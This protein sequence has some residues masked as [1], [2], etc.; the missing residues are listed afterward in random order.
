[1]L[2]PKYAE[3]EQ[4]NELKKIYDK[5]DTLKSDLA[6]E[7]SG[8]LAAERELEKLQR[9]ADRMQERLRSIV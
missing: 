6:E 5:I 4:W 2:F 9:D 3:S 8:S 1:M 7:N